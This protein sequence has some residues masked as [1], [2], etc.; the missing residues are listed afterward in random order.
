MPSLEESLRQLKAVSHE[1]LSFGKLV[2]IFKGRGFPLFLILFS[3]PFCFPITIPGTSAPFGLALAFMGLRIALGKKMWWPKAWLKKEI[4]SEHVKKIV[5][6][7]E[8]GHSKIKKFVHPR[9]TFLSQDSRWHHLHGVVIFV[10]ALLLALP[11]P[12]PFTNMICAL[13]ILFL[14]IGMLEDD[15]LFILLAYIISFLAL[16]LFTGLV[17]LGTSLI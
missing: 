8:W 13:P 14:G 2:G 6:W 1:N 11:I 3:L 12:L 10:M 4:S 5:E 17:V 15:G 7:A 16:T 9:L